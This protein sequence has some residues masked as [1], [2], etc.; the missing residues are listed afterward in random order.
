MPEIRRINCY[1]NLDNPLHKQA[2]AMLEGLP[3]RH[4]METILT[5]LLRQQDEQRYRQT[6]A[7]ALEQSHIPEHHIQ[8][9]VQPPASAETDAGVLDFLLSMQRGGDFFE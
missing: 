4:R 3:P 6:V 7:E 1:F 2:W 8:Q 9:E 5:A